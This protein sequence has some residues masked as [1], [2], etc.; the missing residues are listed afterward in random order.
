MTG[1][2]LLDWILA[3]GFPSLV[4]VVVTSIFDL[5]RDVRRLKKELEVEEKREQFEERQLAQTQKHTMAAMRLQER[6]THESNIV[7][8]EL[9]REQ[10]WIDLYHSSLQ[11]TIQKLRQL[12]DISRGLIRQRSVLAAQDWTT[13]EDEKLA[14]DL[15]EEALAVARE[16]EFAIIILGK[17][18]IAKV[19]KDAVDKGRIFVEKADRNEPTQE[20]LD[21]FDVALSSFYGQAAESV[22]NLR[23]DMSV[24]RYRL[25]QE[26]WEDA[27]T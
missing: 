22:Q 4:G 16:I 7:R 15:H 26:F 2:T 13:V 3:L 8:A 6:V 10:Q 1:N 18:A 20:A 5:K 12:S 25:E 27:A 19:A 9:Q 17:G 14:R 24:G 23:V 21:D 11:L